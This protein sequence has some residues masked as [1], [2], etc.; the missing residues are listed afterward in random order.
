MGGPIYP[1]Q[2]HWQDKKPDSQLYFRGVGENT[3]A[4]T[5]WLNRVT[6]GS[7][8]E[9]GYIDISPEVID[10]IIQA[11]GGGAVKF[12]ERSFYTGKELIE[13]GKI[14]SYRETPLLR[15]II[16]EP[17]IYTSKFKMYDML[18][19]SG[20][21]LY[22]ADKSSEFEKYLKMAFEDGTITQKEV[23]KFRK[24]FIKNQRIIREH[25]K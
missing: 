6:G 14:V 3:K 13:E 16:V 18:D 17:S 15:Q 24:R 22:S 19:K 23:D 2:P 8:K 21:I 1:D 25:R 5:D 11:F 7:I 20:R 12:L 9:S 4:I 10:H